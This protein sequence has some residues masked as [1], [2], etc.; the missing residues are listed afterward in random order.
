MLF[1]IFVLSLGQPAFANV[2]EGVDPNNAMHDNTAEELMQQ[3]LKQQAAYD[4]LNQNNPFSNQFGQA[5]TGPNPQ[6][7][8]ELAAK[9]A[10]VQR[11]LASPATQAFLGFFSSPVFTSAVEQIL[12]SPNRMALLYTQAGW[13]VFL[14]LFRAWRSSKLAGKSWYWGLW[15][16]LWTSV[17]YSAVAAVVI[18]TFWLGSAYTDIVKGVYN[19]VTQTKM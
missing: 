18:P 13:F 5:P 19:I 9:L 15:L 17:V 2:P 3:K 10:F 6:L 12:K 7:N 8:P 11:M 16:N 4:Q 1:I 14:L